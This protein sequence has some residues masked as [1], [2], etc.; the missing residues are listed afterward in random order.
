[1]QLL[2]GVYGLWGVKQIFH[3]LAAQIHVHLLKGAFAVHEPLEMFIDVLPLDILPV[4]QPLE[5][6]EEIALHLGFVK[7]AVV[8][9]EDGFITP[10]TQ[11]LRFFHHA[12]VEITLLLV[13]RFGEDVNPKSFTCN[14]LHGG[15]VTVAGIIVQTQRILCSVLNLALA[16]GNC[17]AFAHID[18][19]LSCTFSGVFPC[20]RWQ[21]NNVKQP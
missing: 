14:H 10:I 17:L 19:V 13:G 12:C 20:L 5:V 18:D 6:G 3:E 21:R 7:E 1:M 11:Y 2:A 16:Q 8:L 15:V 9:V 4:C